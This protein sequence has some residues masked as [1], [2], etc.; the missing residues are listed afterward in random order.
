M[1]S[2]KPKKPGSNKGYV[3]VRCPLPGTVPEYNSRW[4]LNFN[5][6]I[7]S[8]TRTRI[9]GQCSCP[10]T[11]SFWSLEY[12]STDS[13][14]SFSVAAST[15]FCCDS[16]DHLCLQ[17]RMAYFQHSQIRCKAVH[18]LNQLVVHHTQHLLY[19]CNN[20]LLHCPL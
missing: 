11:S 1:V 8:G 14:L 4:E 7:F 10:G 3:H 13:S 6:P 15:S 2:K 18:L 12:F 17:F 5:T 19:L 20:A 9:R 16:L